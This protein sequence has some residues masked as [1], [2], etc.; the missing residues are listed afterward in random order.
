[1]ITEAAINIA[2]YMAS[3]FPDPQNVFLVS[4]NPKFHFRF[5]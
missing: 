4:K 1:M 5:F 2:F 3:E